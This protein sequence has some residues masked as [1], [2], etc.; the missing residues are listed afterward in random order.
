M[1]VS[2]D[3]RVNALR[4]NIVRFTV[5]LDR[6]NL[7]KF[8]STNF[9]LEFFTFRT[10]N[11]DSRQIFCLLIFQIFEKSENFS[12]SIY[13]YLHV[14]AYG[15]YIQAFDDNLFH[16]FHSGTVS[17]LNY[18]KLLLVPDFSNYI[19]DAKTFIR[20]SWTIWR[21]NELILNS[22]SLILYFV[23][24]NCRLVDVNCISGVC[25][26]ETHR[27]LFYL[28][29]FHTCMKAHVSLQVSWCRKKFPAYITGMSFAASFCMKFFVLFES[30]FVLKI[31]STNSTAQR[32]SKIE[33]FRFFFRNR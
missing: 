17:L 21:S 8:L 28:I 33:Q 22:K 2:D 29:D 10:Y 12:K 18:R 16:R 7:D 25:L 11:E 31:F 3:H 5:P 27:F 9:A 14:F 26:F 19:Q 1:I 32:F 30:M 20:M 6:S 23:K 15:K 13:M 4:R 24:Y